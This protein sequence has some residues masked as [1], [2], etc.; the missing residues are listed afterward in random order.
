M[1][2]QAKKADRNMVKKTKGG[3]RAGQN[4]KWKQ[5]WLLGLDLQKSLK[6]LNIQTK[7]LSKVSSL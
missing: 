6:I 3:G 1:M 7:N 5:T 4:A 2:E